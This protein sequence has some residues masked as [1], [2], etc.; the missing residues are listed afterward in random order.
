[1][2]SIS[3][4]VASVKLFQNRVFL[5]FSCNTKIVNILYITLYYLHIFI[6]K[7]I[8]RQIIKCHIQLFIN[9]IEKSNNKSAKTIK[10]LLYVNYNYNIY[11]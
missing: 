7:S 1:M 3:V 2:S 8:R 10:N 4:V 6:K 5:T 9:N 11:I